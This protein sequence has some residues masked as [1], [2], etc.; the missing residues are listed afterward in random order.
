MNFGPGKETW[1][2][3]RELVYYTF[4]YNCNLITDYSCKIRWISA[5]SETSVSNLALGN[6]FQLNVFSNQQTKTYLKKE[7]NL[8]IIQTVE[9]V[10]AVINLNVDP[11]P[12]WY[13]FIIA[14]ID[15]KYLSYINIFQYQV[16]NTTLTISLLRLNHHYGYKSEG[17]ITESNGEKGKKKGLDSFFSLSFSSLPM[18]FSWSVRLQIMHENEIT[19]SVQQWRQLLHKTSLCLNMIPSLLISNMVLPKPR[20]STLLWA[21]AAANTIIVL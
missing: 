4:F 10:L 5:M 16:L 19:S 17:I 20:C 18:Q 2:K 1:N 12:V 6:I 14:L 3:G 15:L 13:I 11:G 9:T 7:L 8:V 21:F